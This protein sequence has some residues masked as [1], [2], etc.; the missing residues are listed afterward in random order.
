MVDSSPPTTLCLAIY[1]PQVPAYLQLTESIHSF[2]YTWPVLPHI[3]LVGFQLSFKIY[4]GQE[5]WIPLG[6]VR[7]SPWGLLSENNHK[8]WNH[9]SPSS[10]GPAM[11]V[12]FLKVEILPFHSR[13]YSVP[14]ANQKVVKPAFQNCLKF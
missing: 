3:C 13:S 9:H 12:C 11:H 14:T 1:T 5:A 10:F 2:T 4:L 8:A 7:N 6:Y